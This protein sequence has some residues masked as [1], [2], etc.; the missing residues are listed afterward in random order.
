MRKRVLVEYLR[1]RER[2]P[3]A[4]CKISIGNRGGVLKLA[5]RFNVGAEV[6]RSHLLRCG[7]NK[8]TTTIGLIFWYPPHKAIDPR[9]ANLREVA[10]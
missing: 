8:Q 3:Q 6:V 4:T 1:A 5:D 7:W 10:R 9:R 2:P